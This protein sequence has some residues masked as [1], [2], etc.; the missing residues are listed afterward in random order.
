MEN[1]KFHWK[2]DA[3]FRRY[4]N[5][6]RIIN[7]SKS[8]KNKVFKRKPCG[9]E[10]IFVEKQNNIHMYFIIKLN[11]TVTRQSHL[12]RRPIWCI[13]CWKFVD[14]FLFRLIKEFLFYF[15]ITKRC[16]KSSTEKDKRSLCYGKCVFCQRPKIFMGL[17]LR[18][19][20]LTCFYVNL[21]CIPMY[22]MMWLIG[23]WLKP[24]ILSASYMKMRLVCFVRNMVQFS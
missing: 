17:F 22:L 6:Q 9:G 1:N 24:L 3:W 7:S 14:F 11:L 2:Y 23:F 8:D 18:F 10:V 15:N 20:V 19:C 21:F 13:S 4:D 16:L 12:D 5:F